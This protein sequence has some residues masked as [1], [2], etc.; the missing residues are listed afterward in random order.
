MCH[1]LQ[2]L[3]FK[4]FCLLGFSMFWGPLL[5]WL[6]P[7]PY[8]EILWPQV[9]AIELINVLGK[10][11]VFNT[12][13]ALSK[14]LMRAMYVVPELQ[15]GGLH[16]VIP[17]GWQRDVA[18]HNILENDINT[19]NKKS[20]RLTLTQIN[21]CLAPSHLPSAIVTPSSYCTKQQHIW[22]VSKRL[23]RPLFPRS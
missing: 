15:R 12:S 2:V 9:W 21:F 3:F 16:T 11:R 1:N 20:C 7:N 19:A 6:L 5:L 14:P 4:R 17:H 8:V 10:K 22:H 23:S 13:A 18:V